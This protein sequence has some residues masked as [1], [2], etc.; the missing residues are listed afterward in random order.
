MADAMELMSAF[1]LDIGRHW[2]EVA[3]RVQRA[4]AEAVLEVRPGSPRLFWHELP[5]GHSKSTDAGCLSI[6]WL[7]SQA[8]VG[9]EG[10]VVS[11]DEDQSNRLLNRART[12][13]RKTRLEG[14]VKVESKRIV[15]VTTG[16]YVVALAADVA[17]SEGIL[18]PWVVV[19]ELPR[20][21]STQGAKDMW[22]SVFSGH[23]KVPG[24][25]LIV[26]GHAGDPA[27][28][29]Y[30]LRERARTSPRWRFVR[31]DGPTPWLDPEDLEEQK[32]LLLPSQFAQ[33]YLNVWT[34]GEDRLADRDDVAACVGDHEVLAPQP[35]VRYVTGLDVGLT[36]DRC[37]A[38]ICHR[39][40]DQVV[41]DRQQ[42]WA[43]S[44]ANPV[45]LTVV[46]EWL[47]LAHRDYGGPVVADPYQA[48]HL[49]QRLRAA[50]V[51][52]EE[53]TFSSQSVGR[54]AVTLFRL[55][56]DRGLL[57]P[58]DD[59]LVDELSNARLRETSPG[60]FRIDHDAAGHDDRVIS[61]ALAAQRLLSRPAGKGSF[62]GG[63]MIR[64]V[65]PAVP[66]ENDRRVAARDGFNPWRDGGP[67]V[68]PVPHIS[69][70]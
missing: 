23:P 43:G 40:G 27:H 67:W 56:K 65:L 37:V 25:R 53:F 3:T 18:S 55:I 70:R 33:R 61:L 38:T 59:G 46:E 68:R 5:K 51:R 54:L 44:K 36:N 35:G 20:W 15:N 29:S 21:K 52:V 50:G 41:V 42:V 64:S 10:Y 9:D 8:R 48:V 19:D 24:A 45:S 66:S 11:S 62:G 17:S 31:V 22:T 34:A 49:A 60:V 32:A 28:W 1:T 2:G 58:A 30:R 26:L 69:A 16:A 63:E 13:V 14:H 39:D 7:L 6:C 47:R 4:N 12:V 57:L